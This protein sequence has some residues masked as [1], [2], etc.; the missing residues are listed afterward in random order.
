MIKQ[1]VTTALVMVL[2]L[3]VSRFQHLQWRLLRVGL[4]GLT[5]MLRSAL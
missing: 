2:F 1:L 3:L 4:Q 5:L